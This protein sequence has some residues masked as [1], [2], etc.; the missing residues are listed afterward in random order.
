MWRFMTVT[1]GFLAIAFYQLSGGADYVPKDG[2]RQSVAQAKQDSQFEAAPP[3]TSG[4]VTVRRETQTATGQAGQTGNA[5]IVLA[6]AKAVGRE[7]ATGKR[8]RLISNTSSDASAPSS[9]ILPDVEVVSADP[10]KITRLVAAATTDARAP[11]APVKAERLTGEERRMVK[12][13]RVNMRAGPGTGFEV[14][15]QLSR[16][17]QVAILHDEGNGWVELRVIDTGQTGW[18]A[19]FLLVAAN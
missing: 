7:E 10:D 2:S 15:D 6:S 13:S 16:G 12:S 9:R 3:V 4:P 14:V 19:D 11:V 8:I 18:M 17:T 1:F 5:Q